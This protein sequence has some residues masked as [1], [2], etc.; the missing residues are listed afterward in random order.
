MEGF[1]KFFIREVM[2][3]LVDDIRFVYR[4]NFVFFDLLVSFNIL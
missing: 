4:R 1:V 2:E 3:I